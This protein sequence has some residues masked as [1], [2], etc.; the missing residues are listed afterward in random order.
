MSDDSEFTQ[1]TRRWMETFTA[2][3]MHDW[4]RYVKTS[5]LSMA[6][7]AILMNL[8]YRHP[9]GMSDLSERMGITLAAASQ[10]VDKLVQSG[11]VERSEDPNDRRAKL[12]ALSDKGRVLIETGMEERSRWVDELVAALT[13]VEHETVAAALNTLTQAAQR[14]EIKKPEKFSRL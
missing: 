10:L 9:C 4:M 14:I 2:R 1:I 7:F 11:L 12:L 6:Q 13:P 8:R 5:G 3:S